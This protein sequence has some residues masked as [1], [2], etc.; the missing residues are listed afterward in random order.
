MAD[1][2]TLFT[3]RL[4]QSESGL[5]LQLEEA[6]SALVPISAVKEEMNR[7]ASLPG[8]LL[9]LSSLEGNSVGGTA[10]YRD[11][12]ARTLSLVAVRMKPSRRE[13][14]LFPMMK[15]SLPLF[16]SAAI[17]KA[18]TLVRLSTGRT[19]IPFPLGYE[20]PEWVSPSL[21]A[22]GFQ[23]GEVLS[24]CSVEKVSRKQSTVHQ[25]DWDRDTNTAGAYA[26]LEKVG[27]ES[28]LDC[29]QVRLAVSMAS[30]AGSLKTISREGHTL[31]MVGFKAF[32]RYGV[33]TVCVY[34][35]DSIDMAQFGGAILHLCA[36]AK[37]KVLH[38]LLVG[39]GQRDLV[40]SLSDLSGS[41]LKREDLQL[42]RKVL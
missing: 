36:E 3:R 7:F 13:G 40:D 38:F 41:S 27:K 12:I 19:S 28:G 24:H 29:S 22:A 8:A 15:S 17:I 1:S 25:L 23:R 16:R 14:L 10:A 21:E 6:P 18:E 34:D 35:P 39:Q 11:S 4:A 5:W 37:V 33:V 32:S 30:G 26:L 2:S 9:Y 31:G 42:M 20:L